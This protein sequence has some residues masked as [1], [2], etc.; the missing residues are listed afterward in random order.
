MFHLLFFFTLVLRHRLSSIVLYQSLR[1]PK[2]SGFL[3]VVY[4]S[5]RFPWL[6]LLFLNFLLPA[7]SCISFCQP[8]Y[9]FW[10]SLWHEDI[11][12]WV[13]SP[14][15]IWSW[16]WLNL[17]FWKKKSGTDEH[18]CDV[19]WTRADLWYFKLE[20]QVL[21]CLVLSQHRLFNLILNVL[22]HNTPHTL[23]PW[24]ARSMQHQLF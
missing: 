10:Q 14:N 24:T 11:F 23:L 6:A 16:K 15:F 20:L 1:L 18:R 22:Y 12:L 21:C 17:Y 19:L 13:W 8:L 5:C 4:S 9:S 3:M 7:W 2:L